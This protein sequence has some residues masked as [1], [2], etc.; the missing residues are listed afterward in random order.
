MDQ[1]TLKNTGLKVS[2]IC[3]GTMTFGGQTDEPAATRMI[4]LCIDSGIN[5]LDTANAY[6]N[7]GSEA[8]LGKIIKNKRS[9]VVLASKVRNKMGEGPDMNGLSRAAIFRAIDDSLKRLGTD[10]LDIYYL[11]LPDYSVPIE[12]SLD[13]MNTL[14]KQG[15]IR[16]VANSNYSGWQVLQMLWI[17]KQ[18]GYTPALITQPMYNLIAR[19]IEQE[20][21]PMCKEFGVSTVVY[22]PLAG[23]LLTGK[24]QRQAPLPGTRFDKNQ[25]YLD[26]YWHQADFDA[27][28]ELK[29]VAEKSGRSLL[30]LALNWLYH[31]SA[32]DCIILGASRIEQL[33]QDLKALG[34]GPLDEQ[35]LN[36]CD[37]VWAKLRGPTPKYN[38]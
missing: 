19:G 33:E 35:T 6:N 1:I 26:R 13:A 18:N 36:A 32:S 27:V 22:N 23:G 4:D 9:R 12:E 10:Y 30:S 2:R 11:H 14:V 25:M 37:Q 5:F 31:H 29:A 21:L 34:D 28:D 3:F 16:H 38:R 7:G 20:Y 24:Q 15:K 8:M 17:A